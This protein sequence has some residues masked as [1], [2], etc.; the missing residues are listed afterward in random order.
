MTSILTRLRRFRDEL[1]A[2]FQTLHRIQFS[3]PWANSRPR[4]G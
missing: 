4:R 3:A 2:S 1:L